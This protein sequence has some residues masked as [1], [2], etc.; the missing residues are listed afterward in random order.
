MVDTDFRPGIDTVLTFPELNEPCLTLIIK[1]YGQG[2]KNHLKARCHI[3]VE[4]SVAGGFLPRVNCG[5][6]ES[7]LT[8][9][10]VAERSCQFVKQRT[11]T[12]FVHAS[13]AAD[14]FFLTTMEENCPE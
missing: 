9:V 8:M 6:E 2:I 12:A 4:P 11:F 1:I 5:R 14:Y 7:A 10:S 3:V 13:D